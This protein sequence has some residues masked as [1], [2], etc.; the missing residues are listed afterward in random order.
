[1]TITADYAS[2]CAGMQI[3]FT[4]D[5]I[6]GGSN[7]TYQWLLNGI[8]TGTNSARYATTTLTKTDIV[9][10]VV[11][12]NDICPE[13][14][15]SNSI[16]GLNIDPY[17]TPAVSITSSVTAPVCPGT[18]I[19]FTANVAN[20]GAD[21]LYQWMVNGVNAGANS[22]VFSSSNLS[23][24]DQV[25]CN[26]TNQGGA[27]LTTLFAQ[28]NVITVALI[29]NPDPYPA[30]TVS[31]SVDDIIIGTSITFTAS[32][33]NVPNVLGYQ[34]KVNGVNTGDD[35][36]FFSTNKLKPGD[37]V[38]CAATILVGCITSIKSAAVIP[39][40]LGLPLIQIPNAFT[41]NG[42]GINDNWNI[43]NL[44]YYPNCYI[45][46]YNRYGMLIYQSQ[47]YPIPWDGTYKGALLPQATYYYVINPGNG[48]AAIAGS[49]T[50]LR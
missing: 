30:I 42:D 13:T 37:S 49:V 47:K 41:P 33:T 20:G 44:K 28:S 50:V 18:N 45:S 11:S 23:D 4:A 39:N 32:V 27:C 12:N 14:G 25:S 35:T 48:S 9:Q 36:P 2:A 26:I 21:P 5:V 1:V 34:W 43:A 31:P 29:P 22:P 17:A 3:T 40:I 16:T 6:N 15:T 7:P 19:T 24:K 8:Q 38:S 10:C 46:V